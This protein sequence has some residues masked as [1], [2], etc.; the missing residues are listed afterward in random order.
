[1]SAN[2]KTV[3]GDLQPV[4]FQQITNLAASTGLTLPPAGAR[5]A[6]IQAIGQAI[7]WR[8]DGTAPTA[9]VGMQI[10]VGQTLT[11]T[12]PLAAL[13]MIQAAASATANITYYA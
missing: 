11:Y 5:M 12:G 1:M 6:L 4:G 8:D 9:T 7:S 3:Q 13:K 10:A 2:V